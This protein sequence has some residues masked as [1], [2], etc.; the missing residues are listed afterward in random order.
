VPGMKKKDKNR[1]PAPSSKN[2]PAHK[3]G[4]RRE[5]NR[6]NHEKRERRDERPKPP[7]SSPRT[8]NRPPRLARAGLYG[9]HAVRAAFLNPERE[10]SALYVT[11]AAQEGFAETLKEAQAL[12]LQRPAPCLVDKAALEAALPEGAVHQGLALVSQ[13]LAEID[14]VEIIIRAGT[15]KKSTIVIL[16]Q[17]TDPHNIGA[18]MRSACAFGA[19]GMVMQRKHAPDLSG[20]AGGLLAKTACGA[21]EHMPV[22]YE[23]NLSRAIEQLQEAG[24]FVYGLD[25]RGEDITGAKIAGRAALVMGAE[26]PGL[27]HLV[28][29]HCDALL[30]LPMQG[31]MP[32]IMSRT[33]PPLRSMR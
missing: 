4:P 31:P 22:A 26:G 33:L 15:A 8:E 6:G 23:T 29:E 17:V 5:E 20:P 25:E 12:G 18:I 30:S 16:D 1:G 10:I 21:L 19:V 13:P 27:R 7:P 28:K 3:H 2:R 11:E 24:Y 9:F 14:L 32:S